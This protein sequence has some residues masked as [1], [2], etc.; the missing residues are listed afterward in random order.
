MLTTKIDRVEF[1]GGPLDGLYRRLDIQ[2][3]ELNDLAAIPISARLLLSLLTGNRNVQK[4]MELQR[5]AMPTQE[6]PP[7][8]IA[9]YELRKTDLV[10]QYRFL[11]AALPSDFGWE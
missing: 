9:V 4:S 11:G 1:L 8:S 2:S 10:A 3:E 5:N 6:H 7:S